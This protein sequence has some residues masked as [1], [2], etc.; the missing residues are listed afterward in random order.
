MK[1]KEL[2]ICSIQT[3]RLAVTWK[4]SDGEQISYD[5]FLMQKGTVIE[6]AGAFTGVTGCTLHTAAEPMK[7]YSLLLTVRS[8]G[9]L[10]TVR[11]GFYPQSRFIQ[12]NTF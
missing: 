3:N 7:E 8:G 11:T 1:I 9:I 10:S 6:R 12:H 5:L 4:L 2:T